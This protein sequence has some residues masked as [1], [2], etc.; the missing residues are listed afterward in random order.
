MDK[1]DSKVNEVIYTSLERDWH[2]GQEVHN[3]N[4]PFLFLPSLPSSSS[5]SLRKDLFQK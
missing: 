4:F 3:F 2:T 1:S 5:S